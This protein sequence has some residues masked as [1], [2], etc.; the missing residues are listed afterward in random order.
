M[1]TGLHYSGPRPENNSAK[2]KEAIITIK[3]VR[4]QGGKGWVQVGERNE[5]EW[6]ELLKTAG[7]CR[8]V[9]SVNYRAAR[10]DQ[11]E[12]DDKDPTRQGRRQP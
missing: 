3:Y 6:D 10:A 5:A 2:I 7:G 9:T 12:Q 8:G 4:T 11:K 1:D